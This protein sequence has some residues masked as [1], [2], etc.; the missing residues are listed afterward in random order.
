MKFMFVG[1]RDDF[2]R[3]LL[4]TTDGGIS[5]SKIYEFTIS[6]SCIHFISGSNG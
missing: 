5:W 3:Y 2:S 4:K 6:I 1:F